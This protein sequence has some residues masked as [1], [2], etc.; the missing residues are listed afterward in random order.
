MKKEIGIVIGALVVF[1]LLGVVFYYH[2][3]TPKEDIHY[4]TKMKPILTTGKWKVFFRSFQDS[5]VHDVKIDKEEKVVVSLTSHGAGKADQG[6]GANHLIAR[7]R[8][9]NEPAEHFEAKVKVLSMK[10]DPCKGNPVSTLLRTTI[11][12]FFFNTLSEKPKTV[13]G[14]V[15]TVIGLARSSTDTTPADTLTL[16]AVVLQ[17]E[18]PCYLRAEH[19]P[20]GM[21]PSKVLYEKD[22][23]TVKLGE[24]VVLGLDWK[25][26]TKKFT[27]LKDHQVLSE[28]QVELP[29][30]APSIA[31][32]P[33]VDVAHFTPNC[34]SSS[35]DNEMTT[36]FSD[37]HVD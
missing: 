34:Q 14:D 26:E 5:P 4:E 37:I 20:A 19:V 25:P 33:H 24:S 2:Q 23:G 30:K 35:T 3:N 9:G 8:H 27:F 36:E 29:I 12:G 22:F 10:I 11:G 17:C 18:M 28:Y 31:G 13:Q 32:N 6:S 7:Y 16:K 15:F 1:S 21:K